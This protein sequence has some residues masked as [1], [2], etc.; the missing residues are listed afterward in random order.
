[1]SRT[2][3]L[4]KPFYISYDK[5]DRPWAEWIAWCLEEVGYKIILDIWSFRPGSN[6]IAEMSRAMEV[7]DATIAVL[8]PNYLTGVYT[9][10]QWAAAF[11]RDPDGKKGRLIPVLVQECKLEGLLA[12]L[13]LID[14][15]VL[16]EQAAKTTLIERISD[17][18]AKPE[19]SPLFPHRQEAGASHLFVFPG[20]NPLT[21]KYV[22][23]NNTDN[24]I[25]KLF[26]VNF[27]GFEGSSDWIRAE[28]LES[29]FLSVASSKYSKQIEENY[30]L[31]RIFG[32]SQPVPL[33]NIY[34]R[35]N[36]LEKVTATHRATIEDMQ[37]F[38][39]Y[40][41]R[42]F[43]RVHETEDGIQ[44]INRLD[45]CIVLGKPGAGKTTFLK[46]VTLQSL[47]GQLTDE[48]IPVFVSLKNWSDS[49]QALRN[50][51]VHQFSICDFPD[52][53]AFVERLLTSG[54]CLFLLDG[55]DEVSTS[56]EEVIREIRAF[57]NRYRLN[58]FIISCRIAAY[59]YWF[60]EFTDI[61]LADFSDNQIKAFI[62]NWFEGDEKTA[63][64]CWQKMEENKPIKEL[65][66]IPLLLTLLCLAFDTT[67]SFPP[68]KAELYGEALDALL[69]KWDITRRVKREQTYR[70]FSLSRKEAMFGQIAAETF[71]TGQYFLPQRTLETHIIE[72]IKNLPEAE[73]VTLELDGE[74][75]LKSIEAQH[76]LFVE[77]AK[78]IYSF[79]H[80]TFQ[81]YF[82]AKYLVSHAAEGTLQKLVANHLIDPRWNEV[83]LIIAG[84]LPK[85]DNFL[86]LI[87]K[88]ID[89]LVNEEIR[90]ILIA[91]NRVVV[92]QKH[93]ITK[94][95]LPFGAARVY[96]L[97][98]AFEHMAQDIKMARARDVRLDAV[99]ALTRDTCIDLF[100]VL[101]LDSRY[102]FNQLL[103]VDL[104]F[105]MGLN[106]ESTEAL[107]IYLRVNHILIN[108]LKNECYVS[109]DVR[110]SLLDELLTV[111]LVSQQSP[112]IRKG[113]LRRIWQLLS[114]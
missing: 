17:R 77:R 84:M 63:E 37:R 45:K 85:G 50:H 29:D 94:Q 66:S 64:L 47:D 9:E 18:Y 95:Q 4:R 23:S 90:D 25:S 52:A 41:R 54:S 22:E 8:S 56:V 15:T 76:G 30:N 81:E 11:S 91:L 73:A 113:L 38:F 75:I 86:L 46:Y 104:D 82:T 35:V 24:A 6:F 72:F 42:S 88:S 53:D 93:Y 31:M 111:P 67:L 98:R 100:R 13:V 49:Y 57:T 2:A 109:K 32:M 60:E 114:K 68:N 80:L 92:K 89:A 97:Y 51:I 79:S 40:D 12:Q 26:K 44:A 107:K 43:G 83:F 16:N 10:S 112:I 61:E 39:D 74:A 27:Q 20:P 69:K 99:H 103:D 71:E 78:G 33:R 48:R 101:G 110:Y 28:T 96:T 34:T 7:S 65:A 3:I 87:K 108:C 36:I 105:T 62:T 102:D 58:K 59:N 19:Q 5:L 21:R 106:Q 1:M 55:L 14:L 70:N